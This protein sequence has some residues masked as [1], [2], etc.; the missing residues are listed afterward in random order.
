VDQ[1]AQ[2]QQR[3]AQQQQRLQSLQDQQAALRQSID[4]LTALLNRQSA[5]LAPV[6][7]Q[8][9]ALQAAIQET[10]AQI[11]VDQKA[12][13]AHVRSFQSDVRRLY[14]VGSR[15]WAE[16]LFTARSF[17]DLMD[18][19]VYLDSFAM[20]EA[21]VAG[22]LKAE[23]ER[24]DARRTV[25]AKARQDLEPLLLAL[26]ARVDAAAGAV[27]TAAAYD[28]QLD[29][30]RRN[31]LMSIAGLSSQ[32]RTLQAALDRYQ[33]QQIEQALRHP[34]TYG[35]TCPP[36]APAGAVR[37]CG[38]GW[39]HGVG[40][41]QWGAKGMAM[42]GQSYRAIDQHFY[43]NTSWATVNSAQTPIHVGVLW[44]AGPYR[45][46]P[47]GPAQL[48]A[49]GH[50]IAIAPGQAVSIT[51]AAGLQT[52]SPL[53]ASTR[54]AV[55]SPSGLYHHYRGVIVG[56]PGGG[57]V[58]V[59]N[60][61]SIEDYL[62]GLGEVPASWPIEA[63][64]A[65]IVAARCYA[66]THLGSTSVYDVDD[67]TRYQV[68][69]GADNESAAQNA[70]VDQT[71]GQVLMSNGHVIIAFFSASDGGHTANVSDIFGGSLATYPY[72]Q[73]VIDPWDVVSPK[74]TWYTAAYPY[75]TLEQ[76]YFS[77][78]DV[79]VYGHLNGLALGDR[80]ASDRLNTVGLLGS[81]GTK[82]I[83]VVTVMRGFNRSALTGNDVLWNE[84]FGTTPTQTWRYW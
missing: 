25:L 51:A 17:K 67:T 43:R 74:H 1:L 58:Y 39:G 14:A 26:Q 38:H 47:N 82:R 76:I 80:D 53:S 9:H 18:R 28:S 46:V 2:L 10:Q 3:Q 49:G 27:A 34:G 24:L 56:Q 63:I 52:I 40:L 60:E 84:M 77:A 35:A 69:L 61:L 23:R 22:R 6:A 5:S 55:Y 15:R 11:D 59:I 13:Q 21:Q 70:A 4:A 75:A 36:A 42:A 37:F 66:L 7:A 73:G 32:T 54:M 16:F 57:I 79:A 41:G 33:Q 65:Q 62:R 64:K 83:G 44:G 29:T 31:T 78:A 72:L 45:V 30:A 71:Q 50:T 19:V 8:A 12:Y 68:Y 20:T 48:T 81:K